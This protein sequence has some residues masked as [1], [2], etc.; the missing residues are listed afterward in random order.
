MHAHNVNARATSVPYIGNP[1]TS[2][3]ACRRLHSL[4][5]QDRLAG[6]DAAETHR[7][8]TDL[9]LSA[10]ASRSGE[11]GAE[12]IARLGM[13]VPVMG[14]ARILACRRGR[15][16]D[17][18]H[19][20]QIGPPQACRL[21]GAHP[22]Q[23]DAFHRSDQGLLQSI[24]GTGAVFSDRQARGMSSTLLDFARPACR[25]A[26]ACGPSESGRCSSHDSAP[27]APSCSAA[28]VARRSAIVYV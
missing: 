4:L 25:S 6:P 14:A 22:A 20:D 18:A 13:I 24:V 17:L 11:R 21:A 26:N 9:D 10:R 5:L 15:C 19:R 27:N 12:E 8:M 16:D 1:K 28:T 7:L 2:D 3:R 23:P